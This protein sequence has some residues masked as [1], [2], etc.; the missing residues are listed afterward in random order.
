MKRTLIAVLLILCAALFC[1]CGAP[2]AAELLEGSLDLAYRNRY[3]EAY[4]KA[5]GLTAEEAQQQYEAGLE[6][7][8]AVFAGYFDVDL[9]RCSRDAAEEFRAFCR[10]VYS[11]T[12]YEV[13]K[14]AKTDS[15]YTVALTVYP[16]DILQK[17]RT[18][19]LP[20]LMVDW[21]ARYDKGEFDAMDKAQ[22]EDLWIHTLLSALE[23][24]Q[25]GY[26]EGE[27]ITVTLTRDSDGVTVISPEDLAKIDSLIIAY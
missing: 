9:T 16:V 5:A 21:R 7:E 19:D 20:E 13:G 27:S 4:L 1:S 26:L 10:D 22:Y 3:T 2:N 6:A 24:V 14:P 25:P 23:G 17:F 15:G 12:K 8:L 11:S 18:E